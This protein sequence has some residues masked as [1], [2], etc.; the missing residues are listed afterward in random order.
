MGTKHGTV[1]IDH[2]WPIMFVF[3]DKNPFAHA[4]ESFCNENP[5]QHLIA[6]MWLLPGGILITAPPSGFLSHQEAGNGLR[7][8]LAENR[9]GM[10]P[11]VRVA[12]S[13]SL[14]YHNNLMCFPNE[15]HNILIRR[16]QF[17]HRPLPRISYHIVVMYS[18]YYLKTAPWTRVRLL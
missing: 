10:S 5:D 15:V 18:A 2:V 8:L 4:T 17:F 1:Y 9:Y 11:L 3:V 6:A 7:S 16:V 14:Q 12:H 13:S